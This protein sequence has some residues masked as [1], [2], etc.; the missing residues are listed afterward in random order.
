METAMMQQDKANKDEIKKE[1]ASKALLLVGV[2]GQGT[3]LASKILSEGLVQQG[4]DVKM[5]EIHGMSQRGG[6]VTTQIKFGPKVYSPLIGPQ[7]ADVIV[8]FEKLE[9]ARYMTQLKKMGTLIVNDYEIYPLP[10]LLGQQAYPEN[11]LAV[12]AD[13]VEKQAGQ[14]KVLQA[15]TLAAELGNARAQNMVLLGA[16]VKALGLEDFAWEEVIKS[17]LPPKLHDLNS[18]AFQCGLSF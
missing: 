2:G 15:H 14:L 1:T 17:F 10:V 8:A 16:V 5:S 3:I 11:L 13:Y 6:S 18:K 12:L 9:A 7:E 4:Y